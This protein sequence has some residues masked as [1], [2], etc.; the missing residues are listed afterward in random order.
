M[1]LRLFT[2]FEAVALGLWLGSM[3][4]F[5][6]LFA[7]IAI[8]VVPRLDTFATLVERTLQ[9]LASF[10]YVC[11]AIAILCALVRASEPSQRV[12][13]LVRVVLIALAFA[14]TA[15]ETRTI[16]PTMSALAREIGGPIDSVP[17]DDPRRVAYGRQHRNS[18]RAYGLSFICAL[19]ALALAAGTSP[20]GT[21]PRS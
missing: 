4:G 10:G 19:G 12:S 16:I 11:G 2:A 6:F 8:K 1:V 17:A 18:T 20:G 5:A 3:A 9:A 7:P 14:G 21:P 13:T 15:Y